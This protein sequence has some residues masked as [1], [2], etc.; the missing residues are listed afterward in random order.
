MSANNLH[1]L[2]STYVTTS[3]FGVTLNPYLICIFHYKSFIMFNGISTQAHFQPFQTNLSYYLMRVHLT[4]N[5]C[6][7]ENCCAD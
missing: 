1:E 7:A 3:K 5:V 6:I 2:N 4:D